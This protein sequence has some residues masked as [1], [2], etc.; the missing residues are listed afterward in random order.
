M[1]NGRDGFHAE[2]RANTQNKTKT[3][4]QL[5]EP[6]VAVPFCGSCKIFDAFHELALSAGSLDQNV[7]TWVRDFPPWNPSLSLVP[8]THSVSPTTRADANATPAAHRVA[9]WGVCKPGA[10]LGGSLKALLKMP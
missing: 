5:G 1:L 3:S 6:G 9:G 8:K 2:K 10:K 4:S 7:W